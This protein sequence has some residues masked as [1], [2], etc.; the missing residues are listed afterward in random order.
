MPMD[1]EYSKDTVEKFFSDHWI[2]IML[3]CMFIIL[4][5]SLL[6]P[7]LLIGAVVVYSVSYLLS[8]FKRRATI[9]VSPKESESFV[10]LNDILVE[11]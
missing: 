8:R 5:A 1:K 7:Y 3:I 10:D 2:A 6:N 11:S 9:Y 4:S